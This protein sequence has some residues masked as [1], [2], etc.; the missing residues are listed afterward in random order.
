MG[1]GSLVPAAL[2]HALSYQHRTANEKSG[3]WHVLLACLLP[4]FSFAVL[5]GVASLFVND[6]GRRLECKSQLQVDPAI[7]DRGI[8]TKPTGEP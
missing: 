4:L 7:V 1:A 2:A 3:E 5:C 6:S 8:S